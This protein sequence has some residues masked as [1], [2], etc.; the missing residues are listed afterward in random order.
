M[1][2]K[3]ADSAIFVS[4]DED[5]VAH[6][7][8]EDDPLIPLDPQILEKR[9]VRKLDGRILPIACMLYLFACEAVDSASASDFTNT[10]QTSIV[11]TW[12][13]HASRVYLVMCLVE[14]LQE[15]SLIGWSQSSSYPMSVPTT[16]RF[17][18]LTCQSDSVSSTVDYTLQVL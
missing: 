17:S 4:S 1:H 13:T 14:T 18:V 3:A 16:T 9:L 10:V 2:S 12:E 15:S 6:E 8:R 5:S 7:S 11:Q